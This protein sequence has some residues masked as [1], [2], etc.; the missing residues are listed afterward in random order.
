MWDNL[1]GVP[2]FSPT[3]RR[4]RKLTG[5]IDQELNKEVASLTKAVAPDILRRAIGYL[6]TKETRST[7]EIENEHPSPQRQERFVAALADAAKLDLSD[8]AALIVLQNKIVDP[9]YAAKDWRDI[10]NYVGEAAGNFREIVHLICPKP[11][12]VPDLMQALAKTGQRVLAN[13]IDP[14]IAAAILSFG[15][16]FIH[17]F[18]DGNG[19]LHRFLIHSV[20]SKTGFSPDGVIFPISVSILRDMGAIRRPGELL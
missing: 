20:L 19:R 5:R 7:F 4:T 3:V 18:D 13:S 14:V 1:L 2:G 12:D 15:F 11:E 8:K 17:P 6:Y 10:Q 9:R 16:V